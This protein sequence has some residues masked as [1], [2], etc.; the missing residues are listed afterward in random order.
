MFKT[1]QA[2]LIILLLVVSLIAL[3][4]AFVLRELLISDFKDYIEGEIED[5]VYWILADIEGAYEKNSGWTKERLVEDVVWAYMLGLEIRI[6]DNNNNLIID[7]DEAFANLSPLIKR[8]MLSMSESMVVKDESFSPYPLF[9][10]GKEIGTLEV[11]F[12]RSKKEDIFL[13]RSNKFLLFALLGIG[14]LSIILSLIFSRKLT[15]PIKNLSKAAKAISNGDFDSKVNVLTNDEIGELSNI[16]NKMVRDLKTLEFLRKKLISNTAHELRT[17]LSVIQGELE[18]MLDGIIPAN[19]DQILSLYEE[20]KR[21]KKILDAM[22]ELS[23]AQASSLMLKK[24]LI[25]LK[26]F[27]ENIYERYKRLLKNKDLSFDLICDEDISVEADPERLSQIIINLLNNSI[28]ATSEGRIWIRVG[29][30]KSRVFIEVGDTGTGIK[31]SDLPFI[32]ERFYKSFDDGIGLGL[33]I[34]KELVN[35][36]EGQIDVKSVYGKGA[37]FTVYLPSS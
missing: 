17:P 20:T 13:K 27:L 34:V 24:Q 23:H 3:S 5:R 14:G 8:R 12:L 32:F 4:A 37:V 11:R 21:L 9:L 7:K 29:K 28:K 33:S 15:Y 36:H 26:D 2:K 31:E 22:D 30:D 10:R 25:R 35:A 6:L 16:F 19:K 1:L 18:G